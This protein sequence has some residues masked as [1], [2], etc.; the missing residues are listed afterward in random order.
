MSVLCEP[1]VT[2]NQRPSQRRSCAVRGTVFASHIAKSRTYLNKTYR[3]TYATDLNPMQWFLVMA[4]LDGCLSRLRKY[5]PLEILDAISYVVRTGCQWA[6]LPEGF[7]N[8]RTVYHHFRS[9]SDRGWFRSLLKVLVEGRRAAIG[10]HPDPTEAVMDSQSSRCAL[11]DSEKGIDGHKRIKGIKRHV[12]VDDNGYPLAAHTTTANVHD[13]KGA[14]PLAA[15]LLADHTSVQHLK[16]D[17]GY[18]SLEDVF[19]DIDGMA[20]EC[21]KSNFGTPDFIPMQGRWVVERTFSWMDSFRR[22]T[23]NYEKLLRVAAHMFITAC[24]FFMLRYFA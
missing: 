22:L 19:S 6:M 13:S 9:L 15:G 12:A 8:W 5:T 1:E 16:A 17:K 18:A 23:R 14:V 20:L 24:V 4:N 7:P 2:F 11:P 10:L 21:V 3:K